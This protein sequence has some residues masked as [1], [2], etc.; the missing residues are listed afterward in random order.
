MTAWADLL[1]GKTRTILRTGSK[2][3]GQL[4]PAV[5][6]VIFRDDFAAGAV[7]RALRSDLGRVG[8]C[9]VLVPPLRGR[10]FTAPAHH[11]AVERWC[12][13][14]LAEGERPVLV[15]LLEQGL[16]E[17][18]EWLGLAAYVAASSDQRREERH[19]FSGART[20]V[21]PVADPDKFASA[22]IS[23]VLHPDTAAPSTPAPSMPARSPDH[24]HP[25]AAPAPSTNRVRSR[26]N[27][28]PRR[29]GPMPKIRVVR[30]ANIARITG[31]TGLAS[32]LFPDYPYLSPPAAATGSPTAPA[33]ATPGSPSHA[34]ATS[35][36]GISSRADQAAV[37]TTTGR[38]L[39]PPTVVPP[40]RAV[41]PGDQPGICACPGCNEAVVQTDPGSARLYHSA[42]CRR[43]ARRLRHGLR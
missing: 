37:D 4:G 6:L 15:A 36:P 43:R 9:R 28:V 19:S 27:P 7:A 3:P 14:H 11:R 12:A 35:T 24:Q 22:I 26:V 41:P 20:L 39:T 5:F 21:L 1:P 17:D 23:D 31:Q 34:A 25:I 29:T 10:D 8:L 38:V 18:L 32:S 13:A 42:E 40:A 2:E 16:L 33:S 30:V